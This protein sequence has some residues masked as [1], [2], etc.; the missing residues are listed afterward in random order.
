MPASPKPGFGVARRVSSSPGGRG[1]RHLA[2]A[3]GDVFEH[4]EP[5]DALGG[6]QLRRV[7]LVLLQ[8]CREHVAGLHFL[9]AGALDVQHRGLQDAA[10]GERLFRFLLL[11]A[12]ELLD[13]FLQVLVEILAQLRQIGAAGGEDPLA[14]RIVGERIEQVL[15]REVGVPPRA[16][17]LGRRRSG[18]LRELD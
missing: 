7:R 3:V 4:V 6:E 1:G 13:R 15:E 18:R 12:R 14:V 5:G 2:D 9:A 8:R 16:S 10:E 17:P 11:A